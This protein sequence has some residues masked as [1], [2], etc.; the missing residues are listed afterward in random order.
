MRVIRAAALG[1]CFGVRDALVEARHVAE[2]GCVTILGELVHNRRV[3]VELSR[4]GFS[5]TSE[6]CA[7]TIP[8]T[9]CVMVTA[10]GISDARRARLRASGKQIIDTT[11]PLVMF[12]HNTAREL[13]RAGCFVVMIGRRGHVEV[14]GV[15]ED[16]ADGAVIERPEDVRDFGRERIGVVCQTTVRPGEVAPILREIR[17]TNPQSAIDYRE[18]ICSATR[19]RIQAV[20]ELIP[21]VE[22]L[23]VV[24][25]AN[26]NNT[27]GLAALAAER[28]KPTWQVEGASDLRREWF[29]GVSVVG[30]TAGAST[31]DQTIDNVHLALLAMG[32]EALS[33]VAEAV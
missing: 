28:G 31:L 30:L 25:G 26:S 24:G 10:H 12:V 4:L 22:G 14:R 5:M 32:G 19:K 21:R 11:C 9:P 3:V 23:V 15:M 18:T 2:P 1:M 7:D 20:N 16:I 6:A 29:R 33:P 13:E 27:R 8:A 17:R